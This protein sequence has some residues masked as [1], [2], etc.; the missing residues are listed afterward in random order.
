MLRPSN[1]RVP[2]SL[3]VLTAGM[4]A[5]AGCDPSTETKEA[6]LKELG[7]D[8]NATI[9]VMSDLDE[10]SFD[11][12]Y[13][14][15][16]SAKF[17][18][19][20]IELLST[21]GA[22][23]YGTAREMNKSYETFIDE[24]KP[25]VVM[26][27][28]DLYGELAASGKLYDIEPV[29][30]QDKFDLDGILPT[31]LAAIRSE[32]GG[33]LYGLAPGF[34][35][36]ALFYNKTM[37]DSQGIP[38]PHDG[39]TWE[40]VLELAK[41]F[42]TTGNEETRSYGLSLNTGDSLFR[43]IMMLGTTQGL[44]F[45]D[46]AGETLT[47]KSDGWKKVSEQA[48]DAFQSKAVYRANESFRGGS[49]EEFYKQDPFIGG[50]VAMTVNGTYYLDNLKR[51]QTDLRGKL[52]QWDLVSMPIHPGNPESAATL[53]LG[54]IFAIPA[55]SANVRAAWE[56]VKYVNGE[57]YARVTSKS[58]RM[59]TLS[60]RIAYAKDPDG[61]HLE[62]F[63][64]AGGS[65]PSLVKSMANVPE[66]FIGQLFGIAETEFKD[67]LEGRKTID[68][69]LQVIQEKGQAELIKA[70]QAAKDGP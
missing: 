24:H 33:K 21:R 20:D 59:G 5:L 1:V 30:K 57:E 64:K 18:G 66:S 25:D 39:M 40:Q 16:F 48:L 45:V 31:V 61:H 49:M 15:L 44:T 63:Y 65:A 22:I 55:Q 62:A 17:A 68:D 23:K 41:R 34:S 60:S 29:V 69:A 67:A 32:G 27:S 13:G 9:K 37:F 54:T 11:Q 38:Q 8:E 4:L 26:V 6:A 36:Q 56:F 3:F 47:M 35:A 53:T 2:C 51:A 19:I 43:F 28:Q 10:R 7:K 70:K 58:F 42:P 12:Q 50:K 52:P 46:S 14:Q